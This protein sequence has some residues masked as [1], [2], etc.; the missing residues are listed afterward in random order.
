MNQPGQFHHGFFRGRAWRLI[1]VPGPGPG[2]GF[3]LIGSEE[4]VGSGVSGTETRTTSSFAA[5]RFAAAFSPPCGP[6]TAPSR[7]RCPPE[8]FRPA[9]P[10]GSQPRSSHPSLRH[11]RT[12]PVFGLISVPGRPVPAPATLCPCLPDALQPTGRVVMPRNGQNQ[13]S[14]QD[15]GLPSGPTAEQ[16]GEAWWKAGGGGNHPSLV[17][18]YSDP[19]RASVELVYSQFVTRG[20]LK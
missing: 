1:G 3:G 5:N 20:T 18:G 17:H 6:S 13:A 14:L 9:T 2:G 4:S 15:P 8:P 10:S 11:G 16:A 12:L 19:T 7:L